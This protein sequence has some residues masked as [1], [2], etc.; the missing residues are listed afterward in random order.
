[1]SVLLNGLKLDKYPLM[2]YTGSDAKGMLALTASA[3]KA[4]GHDLKGLKGVIGADPLGE[5]IKKVKLIPLCPLCTM[6]WL[7]PLNM[8]VKMHLNCVPYSFA[9]TASPMVV[10]KLSKR[11]LIL[12]LMQLNISAKCKTRPG[13]ERYCSFPVFCFQPRCKLLY[14]NC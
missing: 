6:K 7:K 2:I 9:V 13:S 4:S 8:H 14:G 5:L 12:L 3:L 1:M 11:L 10:L